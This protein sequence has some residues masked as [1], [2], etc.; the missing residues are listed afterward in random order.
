MRLS[1]LHLAPTIQSL[2]YPNDT[3][4]LIFLPL[5]P[6]IGLFSPIWMGS[7]IYDWHI[8]FYND[9]NDGVHFHLTGT[10]Q[11]AYF[12]PLIPTMVLIL[13]N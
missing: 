4:G 10:K 11:E 7:S 8:F 6:M 12:M 13:A 3:D 5:T 9:I 1:L 2:F